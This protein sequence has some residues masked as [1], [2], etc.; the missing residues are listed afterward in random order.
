VLAPAIGAIARPGKTSRKSKIWPG[1]PAA[2]LRWL[3]MLAGA[4]ASHR[5]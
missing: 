1:P 3:L 5:W 2:G 4:R